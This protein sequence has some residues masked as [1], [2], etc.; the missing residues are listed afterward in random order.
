LDITFT[1]DD[2]VTVL[3]SEVEEYAGGKLVAWVKVPMLSPMTETRLYMYYGNPSPPPPANPATVWTANYLA[4]W[5]LADDP[6]PGGAGDMRDSTVNAHHGTAAAVM[7]STASVAGQIGSAVN[8]DGTNEFITVPTTDF[9][10]QFTISMWMRLG[11]NGTGIRT[12]L[13]NSDVGDDTN[14]F[15]FFVNTTQTADHRVIFETGN[16]VV[17][18]GNLARTNTNAIAVAAWQHVAVTV[19]RTAGVGRIFVDGTRVDIDDS[20]NTN[21]LTNSDFRIATME[22]GVAFLGDLDQVEVA[23]TVRPAGWIRTAVANQQSPAT[24]SMF[25][26]EESR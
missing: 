24:F 21:F 4:V 16:G 26:A 10:N 22:N 13:A 25:G 23:T 5:H 17:D 2:A 1:A 8:F 11:T 9:G 19:D 6:G 12:L 7:L 3:A 15:R 20:I 14:G 18:S